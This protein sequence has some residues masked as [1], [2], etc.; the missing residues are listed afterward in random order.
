VEVEEE[1]ELEPEEEELE[2]GG[3]E[4]EL[5]GEDV[6]GG[7]RRRWVVALGSARAVELNSVALQPDAIARRLKRATNRIRIL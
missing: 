3:L 1:E 4:E 5:G 2:E 6:V 7:A